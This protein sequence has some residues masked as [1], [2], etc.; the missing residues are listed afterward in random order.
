[1]TARVVLALALASLGGCAITRTYYGEPLPLDAEVLVAHTADGVDIP[2]IHYQAVGAKKPV[3]I[4]FLHGISANARH[5]DLDAEHSLARWFAARGYETFSMSLRN[6]LDELLPESA[7]RADPKN[8]NF[9]TYSLYDLP[10][11]I[12]LVKAKTGAS[13]VDFVGHSMGGMTLYAYLAR[14]GGSI[15]AAVVLGSPTR[16]RLGSR[17]E[18]FILH[19]GETVLKGVDVVPNA[20]LADLVVPLT[21]TVNSPVDDL[22]I[23]LENADVATWQKMEAI[24]TG[25]LAGG[26]LRQFVKCIAD[27]KLESADGSIDYLAALHDVKVPTL[28]VAGKADHIGLAQSVKAGYDALGGE[29]KFFVAGVE[30]GF[31]RDYGH[32]D[33]TVGER[34]PYEV[35]PL[36]RRW[37]EQH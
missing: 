11:A 31:A 13:E 8:T 1:M 27:D 19:Q 36:I 21:G 16:L 18:P 32:C 35:Y 34:A 22:V 29:K 3:P 7:H 2:V 15:H 26:V 14:G 33:L 5:M 6:T 25:D 20:A 17:I 28:V 23:N 12:A 30:N 4:L 10:A 9:D 37:F 24:G